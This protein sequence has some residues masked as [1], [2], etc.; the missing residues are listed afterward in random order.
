MI[1]ENFRLFWV[2]L[3]THFFCTF[4]EIAQH[5]LKLFFRGC[6]EKHVAGKPQ[7]REAVVVVVAEVNSHSLFLLPALM[8]SFSEF[9]RTVLKSKLD[10]GSPCLV[11]SQGGLLSGMSF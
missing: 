10:R 7:V 11:P 1:A 3:E 8:S 2:D 4:L 6:E 5:F 9:C